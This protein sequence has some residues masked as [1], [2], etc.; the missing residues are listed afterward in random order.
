LTRSTRRDLG[1]EAVRRVRQR[2]EGAEVELI[3]GNKAPAPRLGA[4]AM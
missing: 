1:D 2:A 4:S 3:H